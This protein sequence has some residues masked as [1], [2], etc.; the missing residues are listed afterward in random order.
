MDWSRFSPKVLSPKPPGRKNDDDHHRTSSYHLCQTFS[1]AIPFIPQYHHP[2]LNLVSIVRNTHHALQVFAIA[3]LS[4]VLARTTFASSFQPNCTLPPPHTN[5]VSGP[6]IRGT[7]TILWNC[8]SVILLCTWNIQ[9][10]NIPLDRPYY[11][12]NGKYG[13][14]RK[15]SWKILDS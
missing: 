15:T 4:L 11:D 8:I 3:L 7:M 12:E 14:W 9:H 13:C 1:I 6:N 5:F 2:S 10:L